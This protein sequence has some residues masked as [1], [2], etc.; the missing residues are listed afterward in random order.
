MRIHFLLEEELDIV[1]DSIIKGMEYPRTID[2]HV[3][4]F[5]SLLPQN[6]AKEHMKIS[7][8]CHNF[9]TVLDA[10]NCSRY[11]RHYD[12]S[13]ELMAFSISEHVSSQNSSVGIQAYLTKHIFL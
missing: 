12:S 2:R 5:F 6:F 1:A 3:E 4:N 7:L 9:N 11:W 10:A 8:K 13:I